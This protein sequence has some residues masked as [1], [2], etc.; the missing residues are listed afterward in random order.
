VLQ[1]VR[2]ENNVV[3]PLIQPNSAQITD[4]DLIQSP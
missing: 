3:T 4:N 2:A 1:Y